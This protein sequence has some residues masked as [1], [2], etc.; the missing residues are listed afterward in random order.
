MGECTMKIVARL[1]DE[2]TQEE[3]GYTITL[4]A[5]GLEIDDDEYMQFMFDF[6]GFIKTWFAYGVG[7][8]IKDI[9]GGA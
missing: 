6:A 1:L 2:E 9:E 4:E 8:D 7:V 3:L 5:P